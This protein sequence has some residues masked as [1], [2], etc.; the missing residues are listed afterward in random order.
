[1]FFARPA[2]ARCDGTTIH[3][4]GS[5]KEVGRAGSS[6]AEQC[7]LALGTPTLEYWVTIDNLESTIKLEALLKKL[8]DESASV[9]LDDLLS[10]VR[11]YYEF[12]PC[13]YSLGGVRYEADKTHSCRL[14]A[15][16]VLHKLTKEQ[17]LACFGVH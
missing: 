3:C 13:G 2:E 1:M 15:F 5:T 11:E 7:Q 6:L 10:T 14:H 4:S 12:S 16:G 17:T 8:D 9:S